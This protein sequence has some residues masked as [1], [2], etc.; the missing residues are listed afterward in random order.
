[1]S[2]LCK[3]IRTWPNDVIFHVKFHLFQR[4]TIRKWWFLASIHKKK[5][6]KI[7]YPTFY[8]T[9]KLFSFTHILIIFQTSYICWTIVARKKLDLFKWVFRFCW[10]KGRSSVDTHASH[11]NRTRTCIVASY[12]ASLT[13]QH[14]P[15]PT[16]CR[17]RAP[18][19]SR[20]RLQGCL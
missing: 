6:K 7:N 2:K 9:L 18:R 1:M 5:K 11:N 15:P 19:R 10:A 8:W 20:R 14:L 3:H 13:N 12:V 16:R 17:I 4:S